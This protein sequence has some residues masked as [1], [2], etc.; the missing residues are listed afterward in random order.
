MRS[1][2][3]CGGPSPSQM[4]TI[5]AVVDSR[6]MASASATVRLGRRISAWNDAPADRLTPLKRASMMVFGPSELIESRNDESKPRISDVMPTIDVT[7]M[8]TP[9]TVSAERILLPR[10]VLMAMPA[11]SRKSANCLVSADMLSA[12]AAG[13][14]IVR[15]GSE[16]GEVSVAVFDVPFTGPLFEN[17]LDRGPAP[18]VEQF[19]HHRAGSRTYGDAPSSQSPRTDD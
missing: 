3:G 19:C 11:V 15:S 12:L 6:S 2:M 9:S 18:I 14:D 7:P 16:V 17:D 4:S 13:R 10:S 8:T 5:P 1:V